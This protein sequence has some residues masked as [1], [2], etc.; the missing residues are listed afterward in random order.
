MIHGDYTS[1]QSQGGSNEL[2]MVGIGT[3]GPTG[4]PGVAEKPMTT[5]LP[6]ITPR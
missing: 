4:V 1:A 5:R 6:E 3:S 2:W